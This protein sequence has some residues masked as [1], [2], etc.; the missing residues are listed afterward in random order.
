M[1]RKLMVTALVLVP[2]GVTFLS[3]K[4]FRT[5]IRTNRDSFDRVLIGMSEQEVEDLMGGPEGDYTSGPHI[6]I[7]EGSHSMMLG[8]GRL[9]EW[10]SDEGGILVE[11]DSSG[12]VASTAFSIVGLFRR[13][14][15]ER[16]HDFIARALP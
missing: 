7:P 6:V 11:F 5:N 14:W 16:V 13:S 15:I 8:G 4:Y 9:K 3:L 12:K 10:V 1:R 2:L